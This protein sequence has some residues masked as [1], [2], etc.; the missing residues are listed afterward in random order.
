LYFLGV[1]L[2]VETQH[3]DCTC[4]NQLQLMRYHVVKKN[5]TCR[6]PSS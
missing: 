3:L 1:L 6:W 4:N 2:K 5:I